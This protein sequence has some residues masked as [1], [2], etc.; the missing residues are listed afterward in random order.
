VEVERHPQRLG[1]GQDGPEEL[2]VQAAAAVVA[3]DQGALEAVVA[4]HAL[5]LVGGGLR[6]RG[7]E[8]G[9]P[10]KPVWMAT[11]RLGER[12]VGVAGE[13]HRLDRT[14][15]LLPSYRGARVS[16]SAVRPARQLV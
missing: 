16:R 4:H 1:A 7:R 8:R 10:G 3:I 11:H 5:E 2:V 15:L 9:E 14:E 13:R 6:I 12:V